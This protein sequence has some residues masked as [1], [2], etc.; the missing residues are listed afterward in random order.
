MGCINSKDTIL[1]NSPECVHSAASDYNNNKNRSSS[2]SSSRVLALDNKTEAKPKGQKKDVKKFWK[3]RMV[4]SRRFVEAEQ[5][6]AGWPLWLAS[7][8]GEAIHGWVPLKADSFEKLEKV[9]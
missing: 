3:D 9:W 6:A 5:I 2:S 4:I 7:V 1:K 8:A